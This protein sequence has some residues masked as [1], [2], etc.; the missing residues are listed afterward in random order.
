MV[1]SVATVAAVPKVDS[2]LAWILRH[3]EVGLGGLLRGVSWEVLRS[4][5]CEIA[6]VGVTLRV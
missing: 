6:G 2:R 4:Q 5:I 1:R 3:D